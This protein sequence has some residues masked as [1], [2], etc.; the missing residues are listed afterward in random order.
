MGEFLTP[1]LTPIDTLILG[2]VMS[3]WCKKW[4]F[5]ARKPALKTGRATRPRIPGSHTHSSIRLA[6]ATGEDAGVAHPPGEARGVG[7][8]EPGLGVLAA[9]AQAIAETG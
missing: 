2:P 8:L 7:V 4:A 3:I 9:R 1:Y 5:S 6:V